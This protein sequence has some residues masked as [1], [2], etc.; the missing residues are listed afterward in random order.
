MKVIRRLIAPMIQK[1]LSFKLQHKNTV[2]FNPN[3]ESDRKKNKQR[4]KQGSGQKKDRGREKIEWARCQWWKR[5][6][7]S[8]CGGTVRGSYINRQ[9]H[10]IFMPEWEQHSQQR[11]AHICQHTQTTVQWPCNDWAELYS[12][13]AEKTAVQTW[14]NKRTKTPIELIWWIVIGWLPCW[15]CWVMVIIKLRFQKLTTKMN[16]HPWL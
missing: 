1:F 11:E 9:P 8:A 10:C 3:T 7:E 2:S 14:V 6:R 13:T 12:L 4:Q 16:Q 15:C 5:M